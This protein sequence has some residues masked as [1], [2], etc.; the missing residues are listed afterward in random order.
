MAGDGDLFVEPN[1]V[2]KYGMSMQLDAAKA[3]PIG[4]QLSTVEVDA[5]GAFSGL[6]AFD[7]GVFAEGPV[8]RAAMEKQA[9]A[10]SAFLGDLTRGMMAIGSAANVCAFA[11]NAT[12]IEAAE[13]MNLLGYAFATDPDAKRPDGLPKDAITGETLLEQEMA[14][15]GAPLPDALTN[16]SGGTTANIFNGGY[17]TTYDDGSTRMVQTRSDTAGAATSVTTIAAPGGV[18][19]STTTTKTVYSA[20]GTANEYYRKVVTPG[21]EVADTSGKVKKSPDTVVTTEKTAHPDGST[22]IKTTTSA[23]GKDP[24]VQTTEVAAPTTTRPA[25]DGRGP[26]QEAQEVLGP[27]A[28]KVDWRKGYQ[29]VQAPG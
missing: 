1:A 18:V 2:S 17:L 4:V 10:F 15:Q 8:M 19:L 13:K 21:R 27:E 7:A 16:A 28:G 20:N 23:G 9:Y 26:L 11:Y 14:G 25:A 5:S 24:V 22:T 12:D 29:G 3:A 6:S